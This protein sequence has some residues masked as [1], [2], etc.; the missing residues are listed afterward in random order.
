MWLGCILYIFLPLGKFLRLFESLYLK[1]LAKNLKFKSK[2]QI[3]ALLHCFGVVS[4]LLLF[5]Y[6]FFS[7]A[8][9]SL[10]DTDYYIF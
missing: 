3:N 6:I 5:L 10:V 8:P 2:V 4:Y 1:H 7:Q 9:N